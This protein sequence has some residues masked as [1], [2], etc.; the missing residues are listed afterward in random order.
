MEPFFLYDEE[1]NRREKELNEILKFNTKPK[2]ENK[3]AI[4]LKKLI[5]SA[6]FASAKHKP[7]IKPKTLQLHQNILKKPAVSNLLKRQFQPKTQLFRPLEIKRPQITQLKN[8]EPPKIIQKVSEF[9]VPKPQ[10]I[11]VSPVS[12][13][14][15]KFIQHQE[16]PKP[17]QKIEW[18]QPKPKNLVNNE[19][20]IMPQ[21][22]STSTSSPFKTPIIAPQNKIIDKP[23]E[24]MIPSIPKPQFN[25][26]IES[27]N[28]N[29]NKNDE[30]VPIP[31]HIESN[32]NLE[33][34]IIR[35]S[36]G[37]LV[38]KLNE[39]IL[40]TKT[41]RLFFSLQNKLF[42]ILEKSPN[43]ID[44][45]DFFS[46]NLKENLKLLNMNIK[47]IDVEKLKL[48][49]KNYIIGFHKLQQL[50]LDSNIKTI[51]CYGANQPI[52]V[53]HLKYGKIQTDMNFNSNTELDDF[54]KYM[55]KKAGK[56]ISPSNPS[57]N[58]I[59]PNGIKFNAI[60]GG[61]FVNSKFI[62]IKS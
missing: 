45:F 60:L 22:Q 9:N 47:D 40:D 5:Y 43:L 62:L 39:L 31:E 58:I 13:S 27:V 46:R 37:S 61:D 48:Y 3:N 50:I 11:T 35:K 23:Q 24:R 52:I 19:I 1:F 6:I 26:E 49:L 36:D 29:Q 30:F 14:K 34:N 16:I 20:T 56:T 8:L 33:S 53:D 41:Y 44:D 7:I 51:Y 18:P 12:Q 55:A 57:L 25:K 54:I 4:I 59:F 2:Y 21:P 17:I 15:P 28:L 38:Y 42:S 32:I 10:Q